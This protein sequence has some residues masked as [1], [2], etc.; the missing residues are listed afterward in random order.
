MFAGLSLRP[1]LVRGFSSKQRT[2][3]IKIFCAGCRAPLYQYRKRGKGALV[4]VLERRILADHTT[5]NL[6]CP[7]C[8]TTFARRFL[9]KGQPAQKIIGG[10]VFHK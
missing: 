9:Y 4:K 6:A 3:S 1:A 8:G 7:Q 2:S 10:K 5:G